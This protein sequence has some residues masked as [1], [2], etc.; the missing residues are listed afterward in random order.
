MASVTANGVCRSSIEKPW[1]LAFPC[2]A[3]TSVTVSLHNASARIRQI[4]PSFDV[5]NAAPYGHHDLETSEYRCQDSAIVSKP[6]ETHKPFI[7]L[8]ES[9]VFLF[10]GKL[11]GGPEKAQATSQGGKPLRFCISGTW[12]S[13]PQ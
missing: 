4:R 7:I 8:S 6:A 5:V 10:Q 1:R 13:L 2:E 3:H 11:D 9:S 12:A